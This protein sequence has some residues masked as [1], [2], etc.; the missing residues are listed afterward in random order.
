MLAYHPL[1]TLRRVERLAVALGGRQ[2]QQVFKDCL[3]LIGSDDAFAGYLRSTLINSLAVRLGQAFVL[4]GKG[5]ERQV[6]VH[7]KT[8]LDYGDHATDTITVAEHGLHGDGTTRLFIEN[9][10]QVVDD[11]T[12]GGLTDCPN[13]REDSLLDAVLLRTDRHDDWRRLDPRDPAQMIGLANEIGCQAEDDRAAMQG[14]L[15]ILYGTETLGADRLENYRLAREIRCVRCDLDAQMQREPTTWE[16]AS[17]AVLAAAG[18][19]PDT[20]NLPRLLNVYR[21]LE[22]AGQEESL[23]PQARLAD[24]VYRLGARLCVDGCPGCLHA[25]AGGA[26]AEAMTSRRFLEQFVSTAD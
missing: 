15:R 6:I 20:P 17:A 23:S 25:Q 22:D 4:H 5:D 3:G 16:L 2:F 13:A 18:A 10:H 9:L 21:S 24:Q 12:S 7:I 11:W 26:I 14:A 19:R 8:P 1:L